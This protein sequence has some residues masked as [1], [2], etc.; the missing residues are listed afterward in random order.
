MCSDAS[1]GGNWSEG[2]YD[3]TANS[4]QTFDVMFALPGDQPKDW[5]FT[6]YGEKGPVYV[7]ADDGQESRHFAKSATMQKIGPKSKPAFNKA[8][9][10]AIPDPNKPDAPA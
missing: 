5:S 6:A 7:Y 8:S 9:L 10:T 3:F 2:P 4:Y 1:R